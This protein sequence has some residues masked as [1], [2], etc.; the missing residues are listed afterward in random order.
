MAEGIITKERHIFFL[1][2]HS[3]IK[4]IRDKMKNLKSQIVTQE[5][6]ESP[7]YKFWI[8]EIKEENRYH[9]KQWEWVYILQAI[10]EN[11][12]LKEG[13]K[14]LGFGV[15]DEPMPAVFAKNGCQILA[16]EINIEE[17]N[18]RGWV[19]ERN[20]KEQLEA[21][22]VKRICDH[23]KFL[24]LVKHRDVDMNHIPSDLKDFDFTWSSCAFEHL[25]TL[26]HGMDFVMNSIDCLRPG[27]LAVHTTEYTTYKNVT[28]KAG[29]T[30]FYRKKD[31][32]ELA[33]RIRREG[34]EIEL[35]FST[36]R[37]KLDLIPDMPPYKQ[38]H[39]LKLVVSK[40]WKFI[41]ATSIG[42]I[43]RKKK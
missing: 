35:D 28:I 33:E 27:G 23:S 19:R 17:E 29:S 20:A 30:V 22:N 25:G 13:N 24:D 40:Q 18:E 38:T 15:G 37:K 4:K 43:I 31:I 16:T 12:F 36:G 34:H 42:L 39:H 7:E 32:L 1:D 5:Q 26:E 21:L 14:G 8:D 9:R 10:K 41:V 6:V 2:L 3:S 11:G